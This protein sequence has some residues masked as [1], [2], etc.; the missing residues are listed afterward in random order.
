MFVVNSSLPPL[1]DKLDT[2]LFN[3]IGKFSSIALFVQIYF[4]DIIV[5]F[6]KSLEL[7]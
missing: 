7:S 2:I 3:V 1:E 4:N 5:S 6:V